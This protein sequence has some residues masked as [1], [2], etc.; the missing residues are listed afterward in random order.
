VFE[1]FKAYAAVLVRYIDCFV[2]D[3]ELYEV[4]LSFSTDEDVLPGKIGVTINY[5]V[6]TSWNVTCL[7]GKIG[8]TINYL[9][10]TSWNVTCLPGKIGVTV[11]CC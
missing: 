5:P 2:H 10:G 4:S 9:A 8:V 6:R 3:C 11:D 7:P 1:I